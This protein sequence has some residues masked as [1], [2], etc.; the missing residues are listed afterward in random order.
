MTKQLQLP[1]KSAAGLKNPT[2]FLRTGRRRYDKL[3]DMKILA[4]KKIEN[5]RLTN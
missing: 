1:L 3:G 4:Q 5:Y 2:N